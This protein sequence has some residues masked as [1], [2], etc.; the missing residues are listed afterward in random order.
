MI[1]RRICG[2]DELERCW[3]N[4]GISHGTRA[5]LRRHYARSIEAGVFADHHRMSFGDSYEA[6]VSY[7]SS[8]WAGRSDIMFVLVES[9]S[10]LQ[11]GAYS[12]ILEYGVENAPRW[13]ATDVIAIL[14]DQETEFRAAA[15]RLRFEN[16]MDI[17]VCETDYNNPILD[18][19]E[20]PDVSGVEITPLDVYA[21]VGCLES[22]ATFV[23][24]S[25]KSIPLPYNAATLNEKFV[26]GEILDPAT[27]RPAS[28]VMHMGKDVCGFCHVVDK[29]G[30]GTVT[31]WPMIIVDKK[32]RGRG[33]GFACSI[34]SLRV[35]RAMGFVRDIS[36][37]AT[38]NVAVEKQYVGYGAKVLGWAHAYKRTVPRKARGGPHL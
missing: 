25:Y 12:Y 32:L 17:V 36:S 38:T 13:G 4:V 37:A 28:M 21:E 19:L 22:L 16:I 29:D 9:L 26:L 33:I 24:K 6:V 27:V 10:G 31:E 35:S 20:E 15:T 5:Y 11:N 14:D 2:A 23:S 7:T 34:R 18:E 1:M 30:S 3:R 8:A